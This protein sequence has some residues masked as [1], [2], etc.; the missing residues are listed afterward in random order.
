MRSL[1]DTSRIACKYTWHAIL[2]VSGCKV[3]YRTVSELQSSFKARKVEAVCLP[4]S[5]RARF[6]SLVPLWVPW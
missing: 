2:D 6:P 3:N 1:L 5:T 4:L